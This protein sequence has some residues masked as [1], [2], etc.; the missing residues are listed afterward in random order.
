M[1]RK[2]GQNC[3]I[4][5]PK[6]VVKILRLNINDYV[7]IRVED[8][9]IIIEPQIVIPKDQA[10]FYTPEWHKEETGAEKDIKEGRVTK[11]KNL[12]ELFKELDS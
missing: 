5:L 11:T 3:Q 10:Y 2:L 9:K 12:K 6:D 4:A 7:D 8:S 1:L